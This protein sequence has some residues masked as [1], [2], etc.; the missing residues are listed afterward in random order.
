MKKSDA[1]LIEEIL[2]GD[3]AAFSALVEKYQK[4]V[5][6]LVWRKIGDF[7][8]AEEV[9]QDTF[10]QVYKKLP[11]IKNPKQFPGWLYVIANRRCITWLR[12]NDKHAE[13]SLESTSQDALE[14]TAYACFVS[15][16][17]EETEVERRRVVVEKLLEKLPESERTVVI[18]HYL[19]EMSCDAIG[20]FLGISPNTVK[21]RLSRARNRLRGNES[22][23]SNTLGSV[24][25]SPNL[26]ESILKDIADVSQKSPTNIKPLL[27][28]ASLGASVLLVILLIGASHQYLTQFQLPYSIESQSEST[29]KIVESPV[30]VDIEEK[31]DLHNNIDRNTGRGKSINDGRQEGETSMQNDYLQDSTKWK[32]PEGAKARLGKSY[33][34]RI[35][36][37][38]DGNLLA[39][40]GTIGIWI[41]DAHTGEEHNL[42]V[43]HGLGGVPAIA[44]S[45]NNQLLASG[46]RDKTIRLWDPKTGQH[47]A[48]FIGHQDAVYSL[49][50][51]PNGKTLASCGEDETIR[52]WDVGTGELRFTFAGH[53]GGVSEVVYSPDGK[54]LASYG[55]DEMIHIWDA[56]TG[57]YLRSFDGQTGNINTIAFSPNGEMLASGCA[58]GAIKFWDTNTGQTHTTL[59]PASDYKGVSSVSFTPDGRTFVST[60]YEDDVIQ[61]WDVAT[62]ERIKTIESPPDTTEKTVFSP[63]GKTLVNAGGDG[64][65]RFWDVATDTSLRTLTGYAEMFRDMTFSPDGNTIATVSTGPSLRLWNTHTGELLHTYLPQSGSLSCIAFSP[66][67]VTLAC[68]GNK[69]NAVWFINTITWEHGHIFTGP[70]GNIESVAFSPDGQ[71][72]AGGDSDGTIHLWNATNGEPIKILEWHDDYVRSLKF[73]PDGNMLVGTSDSG[74]RIWDLVTG[75]TFKEL[76]AVY[77]TLSPNWD[78]FVCVDWG[79]NGYMQFWNL[80]EDEPIKTITTEDRT[81]FEAYSPDGTKIVGVGPG[82][83]ITFWDANSLEVIHSMADGHTKSTRSEGV[84][85]VRYSPDGQTIATAGWDST[86][87]L[88]DAPK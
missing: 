67:G 12:K 19:G 43:G 72:L 10:L 48:T 61:F 70:K 73:S 34:Y 64:T 58:E 41:Y 88:W 74:T 24:K 51:S 63:D 57:K 36:Y 69:E 2:S 46:G 5:H 84:W 78:K 52:M 32:L 6:A 23:I 40:S 31:Q 50:F 39:V 29:I 85:F 53:A 71:I 7:H 17:R 21:S 54:M 66:D 38:P 49:A 16:R 30:I 62:C 47:K 14:E 27:P 4:S 22:L 86:V 81:Y 11:T 79:K 33:V 83:N 3:E 80:G 87:L 28:L 35:K 77:I 60:N 1:E 75:E 42:L 82:F 56:H 68:G 55:W 15:E 45:P 25:L 26:S 59:Q 65:I 9:T 18:L 44:F 76:P 13:Q 37:S 8:V 20:K